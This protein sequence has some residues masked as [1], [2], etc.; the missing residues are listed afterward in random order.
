LTSGSNG[1][2]KPTATKS[3]DTIKT[4]FPSID[5]DFGQIIGLYR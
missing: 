3:E 1:W 4:Y 5:E 2:I